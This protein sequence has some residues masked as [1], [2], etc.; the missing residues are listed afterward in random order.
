MCFRTP[1]WRGRRLCRARH[2]WRQHSCRNCLLAL[3]WRAGCIV[4]ALR[5]PL[6]SALRSPSRSTALLWPVGCWRLCCRENCCLRSSFADLLDFL[7]AGLS[8][9]KFIALLWRLLGAA[10]FPHPARAQHSGRRLGRGH[11]PAYIHS[12]C[13]D[14]LK[15]LV[16]HIHA[17]TYSLLYQIPSWNPPSILAAWC[18]GIMAPANAGRDRSLQTQS[19]KKVIDVGA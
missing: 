2:I 16:V 15:R 12:P 8:G 1:H 4:R 11:S 17:N 18:P 6:T 5:E 14:R 9:G 19:R 7:A 13:P 10:G 3:Q